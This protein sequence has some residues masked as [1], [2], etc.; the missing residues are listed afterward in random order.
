MSP[1]PKTITQH[2]SDDLRVPK[3]SPSQAFSPSRKPAND[4]PL[5]KLEI[6][7]ERPDPFDEYQ[8]RE[9][10]EE[11]FM[12]SV[13]ALKMTHTE[14]YNEA[15]Y[16]YEISAQKLFKQV[17]DLNLQFH[18]W[19]KWLEKRF[20]D[21]YDINQMEK[22]RKEEEVRQWQK[23][24]E[25]MEKEKDKEM[26]AGSASSY[27]PFGIFDKIYKYVRSES[28]EEKEE[29]EGKEREADRKL[30][31]GSSQ[32]KPATLLTKDN[33]DLVSK[34]RKREDADEDWVT[35]GMPQIKMLQSIEESKPPKQDSAQNQD[36]IDKKFEGMSEIEKKKALKKD[37]FSSPGRF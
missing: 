23:Q 5:K 9:P 21:L 37:N 27:N 35:E 20:Q 33:S 14:K 13:L 15:D 7:K 29:R 32:A 19:Y 4:N 31:M 34:T 10:E 28:K 16:V 3:A 2:E 8:R 6:K 1:A 26:K 24:L 17:K 18:H 22:Q 11:F 36:L 25:E 12:L 30:L